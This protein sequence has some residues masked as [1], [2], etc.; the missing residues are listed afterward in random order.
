M[1]QRCSPYNHDCGGGPGILSSGDL[2]K[3]CRKY[4]Q[5]IHETLQ[6]AIPCTSAAIMTV[7]VQS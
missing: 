7:I 5:S 4:F 1:W 6:M 2:T 3:T